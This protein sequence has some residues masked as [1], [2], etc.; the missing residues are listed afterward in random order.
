MFDGYALRHINAYVPRFGDEPNT[1][2]KGRYEGQAEQQAWPKQ[3]EPKSL[4]HIACEDRQ[5][6]EQGKFQS[7]AALVALK[8]DVDDLGRMF[9]AGLE[10]PTF[11]KMVALVLRSS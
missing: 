10:K 6:D 9:E 7:V 2:E 4:E 3:F 11:T 1:W 8:G 5:Q